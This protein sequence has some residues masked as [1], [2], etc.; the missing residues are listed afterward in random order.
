MK[1]TAETITDEQVLSLQAVAS[2]YR[3]RHVAK[4]CRRAL[5]GSKAARQECAE[6]YSSFKLSFVVRTV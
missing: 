6:I 5:K 3:D 1:V 2:E 4:V